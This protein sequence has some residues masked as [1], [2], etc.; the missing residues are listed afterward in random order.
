MWRR[1]VPPHCGSTHSLMPADAKVVARVA[2]LKRELERHNYHYHV[3]DQ[4]LIADAEW[5]RLFHELVALETQYPELLTADSPT[6]RVGSEPLEAFGSVMHRIPMLSLGNA[7]TDEDIDNFD[8]RCRDA[9]DVDVVAYVCEPKFD[10][11]AISL[12]YENG[13]FVQGSTRGDGAVGEDVTQNLKTVRSIP[14]SISLQAARL[15]VRGEV[16]M[17]RKDFDALNVRQ[18]ERGDKQFVNPRNAAAGSLRQL[19]SKLTAERPLNFFAYGIGAVEGAVLPDTHS[20]LMAWL[21]ELRFPVASQRRVVQGALGLKT[22]YRDMGSQRAGLPFDIDGVVYKVNRFAQQQMLGFVSRAPRF[23]IAHKFPAEEATTVL[24]GIDVQ[25]GRTGAIT[26][27]ARLQPVFVGGTTVSNA[28]L[29]NE[30]ELKRKDLMIGDTVVVRRAGD[31]IP[32]VAAVIYAK[33]PADA[34]PFS[35]PTHCPECGSAIIRLTGEA[36]A[37]CSGG[38]I[39]PAQRK[40]ALLHYAQRRAVD[41][42][43]LGDKLVDQL[44]D[45]DVVHTPADVYRLGIAALAALDRMAEKS[46]ANLLAAIENSKRTTLAK[47][48]F[49]L[50]IRHVG[51]ATAKDLARHF[52]T[53]DAIMDAPPEQLLAVNDVGPVVAQSIRN[54]FDEPHNREVV[55]QLRACGVRWA[56]S[57]PAAHTKRE[58]GAFS[59]KTV[60]LTGTL[61]GMSRDEAKEKLEAAGAKVAGSVSKK[62]DFVIAGLDAG[63]KL[64][65][66]RELGIDVLDE[67]QFIVMLSA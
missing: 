64:D 59:G 63:S 40:Q 37:R 5:D 52:G 1:A 35:M 54:F 18:A 65:M 50:G 6:Q 41:I 23:A 48:L 19:D 14:L 15:E 39:C 61:T 62:T 25:V 51:E 12:A 47:F 44:V 42:E 3:L 36:I 26:P 33:R 66:A 7:F 16:L 30:D 11:V 45:A 22:Y 67:A 8:R 57:E 27:V 49:G 4:P 28:T 21:G 31:V 55:E 13:L 58:A 38:L 34:R 2:R 10:G 20:G 60:V 29:H 24:L 17:L 56:E 43:G 53:L 46:A 9:L 32:E